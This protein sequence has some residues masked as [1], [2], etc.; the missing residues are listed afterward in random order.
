ML[1]RGDRTMGSWF[2]RRRYDRLEDAF[3]RCVDIYERL[4]IWAVFK[5]GHL[6]AL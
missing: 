5:S 6:L 2:P 1:R 3:G 4:H